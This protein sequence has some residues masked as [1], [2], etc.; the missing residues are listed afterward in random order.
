MASV[1]L[2][3]IEDRKNPLLG[4][5]EMSVIFKNSAGRIKRT[6][7]TDIVAKQNNVEKRAVI[8][9]SMVCGKGMTD[10]RAV[11]YIYTDETEARKN[12]PRYI[13]L[14]NLPKEERKQIIADEKAAKLKAKQAS[15]TQSKARGQGGRR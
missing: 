11:F 5:Q 1:E 7:A 2:V 13:L 15:A 14:R 4:R 12:L 6:E 8:P 9:I 10:I 3:T